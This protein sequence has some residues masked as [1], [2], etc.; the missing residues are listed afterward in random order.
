MRHNGIIL[1]IT[2]VII[3]LSKAS[4]PTI[5][6][7][8]PLE[9]SAE[10]ITTEADEHGLSMV[11]TPP[12]YSLATVVVEGVSYSQVQIAGLG[13][14][15]EPG[16]PQLPR[17]GGL[18]GLPQAGEA[19]LRIVKLE[20]EIVNLPHLPLPAPVP[21]AVHLSLADQADLVTGGPTHRL[22]D[23]TAYSLNAFQPET[24]AQLGPIQQ[25]RD[26]RLVNLTIHPLRVNPV[27]GQMEVIRFL[28]LEITFSQPAST[29]TT[30]RSQAAQPDPFAQALG[31]TLLNPQAAAWA[32]PP[33]PPEGDECRPSPLWGARGAIRR[34]PRNQGAGRRSRSLRPDLQRSAKRRPPG[35]RA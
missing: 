19:Q 5:L 11:W 22:P 21:Q 12:D 16:H 7:Q 28:R 15:T 29:A 24:V 3:S 17:Y 10:P 13:M 33:G 14:S 8:E 4:A 18:I 25:L 20:R 23:P 26:H 32:I 35:K 31:P 1:L 9:P 6:A 2:L 27:T 34:H 30:P